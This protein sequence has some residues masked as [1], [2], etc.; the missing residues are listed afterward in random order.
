[1]GLEQASL[2][3]VGPVFLFF[4]LPFLIAVVLIPYLIY[5]IY[6][7][8]VASY[9]LERDGIRL[10]WGVRVEDIPM[11]QV[12]WI[13][14]ASLLEKPLPLPWLRWPGNI[15]GVRRFPDGTILEY[16][17]A[18][19]ESLVV[20]ATSKAV[21][22]ISPSDPKGFVQAYKRLA[23]LGSLAPLQSRSV[24]PTVVIS[25]SWSDVPARFM[26]LGGAILSIILLGWV[27]LAIPQRP[28]IA[29]RLAPSGSAVE[30]QPSF[31]LMLLP[32][33]NA[34]FYLTDLFLGLFFYRRAGYRTLAYLLW[35]AG[36][37]TA[38]LFLGAVYYLLRAS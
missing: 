20:I 10:R 16:M 13:E 8:S 14:P 31:R 22:A 30:Y 35:S 29:L 15:V 19:R 7:L 36:S 9:T 26:M 5:R 32:L 33:V 1:M 24:H 18:Q 4:V 37:L 27:S 34:F 6:S 17:A 28:E 3:E 21:F 23:E 25:R 11:D 12:L 2:A 38:F